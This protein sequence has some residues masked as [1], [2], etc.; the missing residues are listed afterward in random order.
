MDFMGDIKL[1][2][3]EHNQVGHIEAARVSELLTGGQMDVTAF[4]YMPSHNTVSA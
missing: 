1:H 3:G 2:E 4:L